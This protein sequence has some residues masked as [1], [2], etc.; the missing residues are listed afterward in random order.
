MKSLVVRVAAVALAI[1]ALPGAAHANWITAG[2]A[3]IADINPAN[4]GQSNPQSNADGVINFAVYQATSGGTINSTLGISSAQSL[5]GT[6]AVNNGDYIYMYQVVNTVAPGVADYDR[7]LDKILIEHIASTTTVSA[8]GYLDKTVFTDTSGNVGP[9]GTSGTGAGTT[10]TGNY[11]LGADNSTPGTA[12]YIANPGLATDTFSINATSFNKND[13]LKP[14][15]AT[16]T[17]YSF[18]FPGND[19]GN[20]SGLQPTE[21]SSIVYIVSTFA[22]GLGSGQVSDT[23]WGGGFVPTPGGAGP[24]LNTPEPGTFG[25]IALAIPLIGWGYARRLRKNLSAQAATVA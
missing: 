10:N 1:I 6:T 17:A 13:A 23:Q 14:N 15:G 12:F 5:F 3:F 2:S 8:A 4:D 9:N 20:G 7:A 18:K 24:L 22:P 25:L 11:R 19:V 16:G 21:Y